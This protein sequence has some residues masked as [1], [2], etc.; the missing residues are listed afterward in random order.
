MSRIQLLIFFILKRNKFCLNFHSLELLDRKKENLE[1]SSSRGTSF[2]ERFF[3]RLKCK[4]SSAICGDE[5]GD[6]E[7]NDYP[8]D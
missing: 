8:L 5:F 6:D 2:M 1:N 3:A 4:I 7:I